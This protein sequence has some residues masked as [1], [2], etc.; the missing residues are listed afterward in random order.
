MAPK[1]SKANLENQ[2][3][4]SA[5]ASRSEI[6]TSTSQPI[7]SSS[8]SGPSS[9]VNYNTE[10]TGEVDDSLRLYA[11][12]EE[13]PNHLTTSVISTVSYTKMSTDS[14]PRRSSAARTQQ[15]NA[16]AAAKSQFGDSSDSGN[17]SS[18]HYYPQ[19][20]PA[21]Q[22]AATSRRLA[23][24]QKAR[25]DYE[26]LM[27]VNAE[28]LLLENSSAASNFEQNQ[29]PVYE[30][31]PS[32]NSA[33]EIEQPIR[34]RTDDRVH[35]MYNFDR[36]VIQRLLLATSRWFQTPLSDVLY[37]QMRRSKDWVRNQRGRK[38]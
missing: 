10:A 17:E 1:E 13:P 27:R 22:S 18:E 2:N 23:V 15:S 36:A 24:L 8:T 19:P 33:N 6:A 26:E 35:N 7:T 38:W 34:K 37:I 4:T 31:L 32:N 30:L 28:A 21:A 20:P 3:P 14:L 25:D 9:S 29:P 16:V 5:N 11:D 12:G